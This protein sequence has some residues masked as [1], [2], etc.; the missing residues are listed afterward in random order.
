[1][2]RALPAIT[3]KRNKITFKLKDYKD[4]KMISSKCNIFNINRC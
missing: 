3:Q 4:G 2:S 1:M